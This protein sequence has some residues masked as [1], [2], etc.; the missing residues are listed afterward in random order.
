V[1]TCDFYII[2]LPILYYRET[3]HKTREVPSPEKG[4]SMEEF[5]KR[6]HS[7]YCSVEV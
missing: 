4:D 2:G 3:L 6:A 5:I 7:V 1:E